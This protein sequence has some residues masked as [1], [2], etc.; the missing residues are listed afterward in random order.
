MNAFNRG[1][2]RADLERLVSEFNQA[3]AGARDAKGIA[4]P[5][6]TLPTNIPSAIIFTHWM[7]DSADRF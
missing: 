3:Y 1:M 5:P 7:C 4:I 6:V 2:R